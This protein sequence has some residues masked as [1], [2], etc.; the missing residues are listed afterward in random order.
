MCPCV[1]DLRNAFKEWAVICRALAEGRQSLILR[2]G[3]IAEEGGR[4]RVEHTGFWLYPTY[5]HQQK[6]GIVADAAPLL[7]QAEAE[8]PPEGVEV[9]TACVAGERAR[10]ERFE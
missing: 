2:K 8:K 10:Y 4:F 5:A 9:V 7:E 1:V 3:G 6:A